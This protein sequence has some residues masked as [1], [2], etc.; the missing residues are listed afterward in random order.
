MLHIVLDEAKGHQCP[1]LFQ[2]AAG[3]DESLD[4]EQ[5]AALRLLKVE[6]KTTTGHTRREH[7]TN[8]DRLRI[9]IHFGKSP[10][11]KLVMLSIILVGSNQ[12]LVL[13]RAG[14]F[15]APEITPGARDHWIASTAWLPGASRA[16]A[17]R[18]LISE[19]GELGWRAVALV[20]ID[21]DPVL[22]DEDADSPQECSQVF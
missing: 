21:G 19:M 2:S 8:L 13:A 16:D 9:D 11:G 3:I 10:D 5:A 18:T 17:E 7:T 1:L 12:I 22:T 6:H 14:S 15:I 4:A 20:D